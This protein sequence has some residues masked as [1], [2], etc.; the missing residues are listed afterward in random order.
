MQNV[1]PLDVNFLIGVASSFLDQLN[2][3]S[4]MF[5]QEVTQE[6]FKSKYNEIV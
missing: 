1:P 5:F 4:N 6:A 3:R 2:R